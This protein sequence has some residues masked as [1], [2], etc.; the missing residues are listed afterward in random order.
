MF[1]HSLARKPAKNCNESDSNN[2]VPL[3]RYNFSC[4]GLHY[5][6]WIRL[7]IITLYLQSLVWTGLISFYN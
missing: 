4:G 1:Y 6:L 3:S 7:I 5:A 2:I